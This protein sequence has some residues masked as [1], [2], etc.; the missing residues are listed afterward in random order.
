M[1]PS[2][3]DLADIGG[4][5]QAA[6]AVLVLHDDAGRA[7]EVLAEML[8]QQP[9]LDVARPAGREVDQQGQPLALV[10]RIVGTGDREG[11]GCRNGGGAKPDRDGAQQRHDDPPFILTSCLLRKLTR[12]DRVGEAFSVVIIRAA[13]DPVTTGC[14]C[15]AHP[16]RLR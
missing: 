1:V 14:C 12:L 7:V 6:G 13:D 4:A 16:M 3:A 9:S 10:E 15:R 8:D 11:A 2:L 5:H